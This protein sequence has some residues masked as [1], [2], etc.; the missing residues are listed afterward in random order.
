MLDP[1]AYWQDYSKSQAVPTEKRESQSNVVSIFRHPEY[2][3]N[4]T[5]LDRAHKQQAFLEST[6]QVRLEG[7]SC[8]CLVE[9]SD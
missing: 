6:G 9:D 7:E 2:S 8:V 3:V 1:K 5:A 4:S